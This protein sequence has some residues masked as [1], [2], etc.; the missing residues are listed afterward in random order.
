MTGIVE[1]SLAT[2]TPAV[3]TGPWPLAGRWCRP[4]DR[5]DVG[6]DA[7]G[8]WRDAGCTP[9]P[10]AG[11]GGTT[12][13]GSPCE[14]GSAL[15]MAALVILLLAF[16]TGGL[17]LAGALNAR[18]QQVRGAADLAALAGAHAQTDNADACAAAG[19]SARANDVE[20]VGCRVVGDEVEYVVSVAVRAHV[21]VG[22]WHDQLRA[23]AHAGVVTGAPE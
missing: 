15:P 9:D 7:L 5:P 23:E 8:G 6:E 10:D 17:V 21:V 4:M 11:E 22:P 18:G 12:G 16:L 19:E 1:R 20:V 13:I 3:V 14:R 2:T